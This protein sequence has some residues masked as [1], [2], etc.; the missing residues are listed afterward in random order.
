MPA[1]V[2]LD[3]DMGPMYCTEGG[4]VFVGGVAVVMITD[5]GGKGEQGQRGGGGGEGER[6]REILHVAVCR[7]TLV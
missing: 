6:E 4:I 1:D 2:D 5:E 3:T 7:T